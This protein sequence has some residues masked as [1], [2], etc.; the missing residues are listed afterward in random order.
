MAETPDSG[1]LA[2]READ[3]P[4]PDPIASRSTSA[5]ML[6]SALLLTGV[7][8]WSLYDEVYGMRPWKSYQQSFVKRYDRYLKRLQKR[9]FKSEEEVRKSAEYQ[10][11]DAEAKTARAQAAPKLAEIDKRVAAIDEQLGAI[12]DNFQD[13]RGRI[14][15]ASY[16]VEQATGSRKESLRRGLDANKAQKETV[17]LPAA[18]G[19]R[20]KRELNFNELEAMYLSLKDEKGRLL[21]D[22]GES[23][24]PAGEL[25]RQRD[26][27]LKNNVTEVTEQQVRLTRTS[28]ENYDFGM[29]Q[30]NYKGDMIVDRCESCH[31]GIRSPIPIRASDMVPIGRGKLSRPDGLARAFVSHPSG[32]LLK[33]HDPEKFGCSSCHWGNG[34]ATTSIEKGHGE[35]KFWLHPLFK[36]ENAEAGCNQCHSA[37][38]VLQGAN[39]L[40]QGKDLFYQ[41]G[42]V[43]C[44]RYEGFDRETDALSN[45]RQLVKQLE[46]E[47]TTNEHDAKVARADSSAPGVSDTRASELLAHAESL[48]VTNSQL[49]A[50]IDQLNTQARY[51]MQDQKKVGPNLKDVKL[52]LRKEWIPEWLKDPQAFRPGTKMPSF[53]YLSG[54]QDANKGN[55]VPASMQDDERKA[56]AAYLWQSAFDGRV[57]AQQ[58]GDPRHG[59]EL[60]KTRGCMACHS[61]GEG[62]QKIGG[63][64]AANLT[65]VGQKEN[66][67]Y[68]VRWVHNPRERWA[69]YCP[70]EKRDLTPEDYRKNGKEFVFDTTKHTRC[71]NDGAE[72]QVQN[73][74][75]MPNFRL[76]DQDARDI[77][78]YLV[79]LAPAAQYPDASFMDDPG[80]AGKGKT[81]IKQ[82]GCAGCHEIRGFEDEQRI[83]KELTAEGATP[84]E[85]LDF[86]RMTHLAEE[87]HEPPGFGA[88]GHAE[89]GSAGGSAGGNAGGKTGGAAKDDK[90]G[91]SWYDHKGFFEHKLGEPSIYDSGK[92]KDPREH[93]RMP[94]PYLTDEWKRALTTFLLGSVGTEGANVPASLFYNPTD[95]QK[96]I[97]DGWWVV[98]KY[99]CMGCHSVQVG[100]KAVLYGLPQY[101]PGGTLGD[102][103]LGPEQL[104]PGL[105]TEGARVDPEWLLRFLSDPSLSGYSEG[106][107][108]AAHGGKPSTRPPEENVGRGSASNRQSGPGGG[109][110]PQPNQ[111]NAAPPQ[112][113]GA[114]PAQPEASGMANLKPQ[115]GENRNGVRTYL[116]VRMPTFSFSPNEL[117]AL[118]RF[119][120]A[121]S[122]QQEPYIKQQAEPL[123]TDE[124]DLARSL[125]TSRAAPC[126][127]CH[128]TGDPG[129]DQTATAPNFLQAGERL[130][131]D[132]TVRWLLDPQRIM[133]GT[134]MPSELF[135]RDGDR[136]V[137]NGPLPPSA[138]DYKGDHARLLTRYLLSLTPEEQARARS[139]VPAQ[140]PAPSG[141]QAGPVA[142]NGGGRP[143]AHAAN[144]QSAGRAKARRGGRVQ[145]SQ[146]LRQRRLARERRR[147]LARE[148]W[149]Q[150]A[151]SRV[152]ARDFSP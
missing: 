12:S 86:A 146:R 122:A 110:Q 92:E 44:H 75:V 101:G 125:F 149:R 98:K 74:T 115:P 142:S 52:K 64:F 30:V 82:Y 40:N 6:V 37:D 119:F 13:R 10:R 113:A 26:E 46:E 104:P 81:L 43:G 17:Y 78:T 2:R 66:Y 28:L 103:Q 107:D 144:R 41:R 105:M 85:R 145:V 39:V 139:T 114:A 22:K 65:K 54:Q 141:T 84:L 126:L 99:N 50:K 132:W 35:N 140:I 47:V 20:E 137:F 152:H 88:D 62:D 147:Q 108:L 116:R 97:Q 36:K 19:K 56:I 96:A 135:K 29:R 70:K 131:E 150:A 79:S 27:Y 129:H 136:W 21:A 111:T 109:A 5:I 11:L 138:A 33:I 112:P 18:D 32:E 67:D 14:A 49:E 73:M 42:C 55:I 124:K 58:P 51:L 53:W 15:L 120:L 80:L 63:E 87:G 148:R 134:A 127:K 45:T 93:L 83:G 25:D 1:K 91:K 3:A 118:V 61:I 90:Q 72:L 123:T 8:V 4:A 59:E 69:P 130:K 128:M 23:L 57:Q 143:R 16:N 77:A 24:K 117:R 48:V 102:M 121:V 151:A 89:G 9:G 76:A 94:R 38:R 100:Q 60:F 71:P 34:R 68:V 7:L 95:Q 133:P 106:L 31:L